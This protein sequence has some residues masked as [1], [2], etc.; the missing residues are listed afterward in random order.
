MT[1]TLERPVTETRISPPDL[2]SNPPVPTP[3]SHHNRRWWLITGVIV[4]AVALAGAGLLRDS[5]VST[6]LDPQQ[7]SFQAHPYTAE[8]ITD[9]PYDQM[10]YF[11]GPA[12]SFLTPSSPRYVPL[13]PSAS[14]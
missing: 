14:D 2:R 5:T 12:S 6:G 13:A 3:T 7:R 10:Q 4:I 9:M 8:T 1:L 11:M